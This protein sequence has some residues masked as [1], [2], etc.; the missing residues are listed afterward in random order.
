MWDFRAMKRSTIRHLLAVLAWLGL[1]LGPIAPPA[2]AMTVSMDV[3]AASTDATPMDM[4]EGMPCCPDMPVKPDCAKDCPFMA[5]C[6]ATVFSI[7]DGGSLVVPAALL[8][9]V[10]P[11]RG[12]K[13]HGLGHAP[14]TRPPRT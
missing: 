2:A 14:P 13:L 10:A 11:D 12:T 9:V 3:A 1:V 5:S 4:P 7:A 6:A 8:A